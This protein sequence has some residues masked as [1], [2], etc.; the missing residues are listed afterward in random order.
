M[1]LNG[2]LGWL[3]VLQYPLYRGYAKLKRASVHPSVIFNGRPYISCVRGARITLSEGVRLNT[4][5]SSNPL[6]CR[7]RSSL[8]A[9]SPGARIEIERDVG[10]SGVCICAAK[11]VTI[12]EGTIIGA[13]VLIIDTDFHL[14]LPNWRWSNDPTGS[15]A[16]IAIGKGCFIGARATILKGVSL[17]DGAVVAT[18]A[19][20]TRDVPAVHL[21]I[22]NPASVQP[23]GPTWIHPA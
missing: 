20:V 7:S 4:L 18:G 22:G 16:P 9:I 19:V 21:A 5:P 10:M 1:R 11:E 3:R 12:G 17:G 2:I 13:D 15:C 6:I 14:P 23:L 8:C